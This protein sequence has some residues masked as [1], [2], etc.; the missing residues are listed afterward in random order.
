MDG[1]EVG[2]M[3]KLEELVGDEKKEKREKQENN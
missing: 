1:D 3:M 2:T